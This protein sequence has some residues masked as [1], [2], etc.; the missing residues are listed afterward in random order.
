MYALG[1]STGSLISTVYKAQISNPTVNPALKIANNGFIGM[2]TAAPLAKLHLYDAVSPSVAVILENGNIRGGIELE[3]QAAT[4]VGEGILNV[5]INTGGT[6][7]GRGI[8]NYG[9]SLQYDA[10]WIRTDT[11]LNNKGFSFFWRNAGTTAENQLAVIS[12]TG[13]MGLGTAAPAATLDII[14]TSQPR[15]AESVVCRCG[16]LEFRK[17]KVPVDFIK[18]IDCVRSN[19]ERVPK[20]GGSTACVGTLCHTALS[21]RLGTNVQGTQNPGLADRYINFAIGNGQILGKVQ[22]NASGGVAFATAGG[23][24]AEWFRKADPNEQLDYGEIVCTDGS[25]NVTKCSSANS[26]LLGVITDNFA[27]VGNSGHDDD[28]NYVLVGLL[29]QIRISVNSQNGAINPG[30]L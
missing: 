18:H 5:G 6:Q 1:G 4:S 20:H 12:N 19:M 13:N 24:Y 9:A 16:S 3:T 26:D 14:S 30:D 8:L 2:G 27:F 11:R 23:D 15:C 21:L 28:P 25:G 29:G 10:A 7:T 22:G 17:H